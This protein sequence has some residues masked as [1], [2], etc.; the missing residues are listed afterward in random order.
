MDS[1]AHSHY[2]YFRIGQTELQLWPPT[3]P[4][5]VCGGM[6]LVGTALAILVLLTRLSYLKRD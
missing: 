4:V 5:A 1:F 3:W 6:L 2:V